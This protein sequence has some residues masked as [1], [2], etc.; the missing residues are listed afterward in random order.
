M[1]DPRYSEIHIR[2]LPP[3]RVV[4]YRA[5]SATPEED[6]A[7]QVAEWTAEQQLPHALRNFGFD[8]EVSPEQQ[9]A[10]LRGYELWLAVPPDIEP[11]EEMAVR[12]FL[13]GLYAVMTIY[14]ALDDPF[15]RIPEGWQYLH[16][17]V[18]ANPQYEP[19]EH[20]MLEEVIVAA[21]DSEDAQRRH[22]VIYYPVAAIAVGVP[23]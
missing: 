7:R 16:Q 18:Q 10:G 3:M 17:W 4:S 14:D 12:R 20:Q 5:I 21:A 15:G 13:G 2:E 9:K 8:V 19:A 23:S 1:N 22:L 6:A 11:G